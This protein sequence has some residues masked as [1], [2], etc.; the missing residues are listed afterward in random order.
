MRFQNYFKIELRLIQSIIRS[1]RIK[2]HQSYTYLIVSTVVITL[3]QGAMN[4]KETREQ[5]MIML[6]LAI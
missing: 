3:S 6:I 4:P 2:Y 5:C 1:K